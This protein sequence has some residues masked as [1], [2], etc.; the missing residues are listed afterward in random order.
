MCVCVCS[1]SSK[2]QP[3]VAPEFLLGKLGLMEAKTSGANYCVYG[4]GAGTVGG[5]GGSLH[6]HPPTHDSPVLPR[7]TPPSKAT[8]SNI[9]TPKKIQPGCRQGRRAGTI[10]P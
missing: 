10:N 4:E 3:V 9:I 6:H 8:L 1:T 7:L 5:G 2:L